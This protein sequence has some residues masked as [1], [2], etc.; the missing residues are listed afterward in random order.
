MESLPIDG[1]CADPRLRDQDLLPRQSLAEVSRF[2][3]S[4]AFRRRMEDAPTPTG[5][6]PGWHER[7]RSEQRRV[8]HLSLGLV[9]AMVCTSAA[10]GITHWVA[11][12]EPALL[13]MYAKL[14]IHWHPLGEMIEYHGRRQPCWTRVD[15]ML[16]R[17]YRERPEIWDLVTDG[18]ACQCGDPSLAEQPA[19]ESFET[20][21]PATL[22]ATGN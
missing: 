20:D 15:T 3:V 12:M 9:Q 14:G 1:V 17:T 11:E 8:P 7:R 18:G 13:R 2:A 16:A 22:T 19:Q 21:R 10:Y 6:G 5:V 4:K